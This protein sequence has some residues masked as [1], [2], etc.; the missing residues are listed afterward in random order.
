MREVLFT[1]LPRED[2]Y[3]AKAFIDTVV[4]RLGDQVGAWSYG[5]VGWL[6]MS[7]AAL[8]VLAVPLSVRLAL[9]RPLARRRQEVMARERAEPPA[10]ARNG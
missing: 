7:A 1:V 3:K 2:R 8:S 6:G 5:L 4:Y 10:E 9:Q